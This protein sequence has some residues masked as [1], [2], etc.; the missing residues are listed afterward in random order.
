MMVPVAVMGLA[1]LVRMAPMAM[2]WVREVVSMTHRPACLTAAMTPR[3]HQVRMV[4][5]VTPAWVA[6]AVVVMAVI[7]SPL[8]L[9][10]P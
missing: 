3:R 9:M 6:A 5:T 1:F 7:G 8:G 10:H 2:R 4:S